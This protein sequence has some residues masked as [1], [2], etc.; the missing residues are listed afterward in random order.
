M[1]YLIAYIVFCIISAVMTGR[2]IKKGDPVM[3]AMAIAMTVFT[4][5]LMVKAI[6][7]IFF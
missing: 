3:L 7:V 6:L 2:S 5:V 4:A 1:K